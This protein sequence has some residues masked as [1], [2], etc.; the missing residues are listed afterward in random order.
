MRRRIAATAH[1][2]RR[3]PDLRLPS[4]PGP[5]AIT[6]TP[7]APC[8]RRAVLAPVERRRHR[9]A[10]VV[11]RATGRSQPAA[12]IR[13]TRAARE[14]STPTHRR[15]RVRPRRR[16]QRRQA[17]ARRQRRAPT[18]RAGATPRRPTLRPVAPTAT[19][20]SSA[21]RST[22]SR[23]A[24]ATGRDHGTGGTP[25]TPWLTR[26]ADAPTAHDRTR[27]AP[28]RPFCA[29]RRP[30]PAHHARWPEMGPGRLGERQPRTTSCAVEAPKDPNV[31]D[32]RAGDQTCRRR[33]GG[34][35]RTARRCRRCCGRRHR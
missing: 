12:R 6:A 29:T 13:R 32:G 9:P 15:G 11:A 20:T 1:H 23:P 10:M 25:C 19:G 16:R 27:S 33:G 8:G 26:R 4:Q 28:S 35:R 18:R 30:P 7:E 22:G 3:P 21:A 34:C 14:R 5:T 31:R 2:P 17:R 24:T